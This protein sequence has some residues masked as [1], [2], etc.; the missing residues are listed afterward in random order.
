MEKYF[1]IATVSSIVFYAIYFF[2][3][4]NESFHH[5]NRFYLLSA[6]IV[7]LLIPFV[8]FSVPELT[9]PFF[10]KGSALNLSEF[11]AYIE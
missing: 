9:I 4:R 1:L 7:S 5:F 10:E 8:R 11:I 6:I 2:L 3:F